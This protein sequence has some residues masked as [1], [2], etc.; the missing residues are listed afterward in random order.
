MITMVKRYLILKEEI[1]LKLIQRNKLWKRMFII[2]D[3]NH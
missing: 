3:S 1:T 2:R